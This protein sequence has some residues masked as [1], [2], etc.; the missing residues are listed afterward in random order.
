MHLA[1][2][3]GH[4]HFFRGRQ[5]H[6]IRTPRVAS[7][8]DLHERL[9]TI[10]QPSV[11]GKVYLVVAEGVGQIRGELHH[12]D[13]DEGS[14]E[15]HHR[16]EDRVCKAH[17]ERPESQICADHGG[18][19]VEV[20]EGH[21]QRQSVD[22]DLLPTADQEELLR[23]RAV[24][25]VGAL[26]LRRPHE[27]EAGRPIQGGDRA[28]LP[29]HLSHRIPLAG[30]QQAELHQP[31][32]FVIPGMSDSVFAR[33]HALHLEDLQEHGEDHVA[34]AQ[35][36]GAL[37]LFANVDSHEVGEGK[38]VLDHAS[39]GLVEGLVPPVALLGVEDLEEGGDGGDH[40]HE[41]PIQA[42]V[43]RWVQFS[44]AHE[45]KP[46]GQPHNHMEAE[47]HPE[48]AGLQHLRNDGAM[49][50][51]RRQQKTTVRIVMER[52]GTGGKVREGNKRMVA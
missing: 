19:E 6:A 3:A 45:P 22:D 20:L 23:K 11:D 16:R 35:P 47:K 41:L 52:H 49:Q 29:V 36:H 39:E 44:F 43:R 38:R 51:Q 37:R 50:R 7:L 8:D 31:G 18:Q 9:H 40:A 42:E 28:V 4:R 46:E 21:G 30:L 14:E 15:E 1:V 27:G 26:G 24:D 34:N 10:G 13:E 48:G 32:E 25:V 5:V 12:A 17:A 2:L 33:L